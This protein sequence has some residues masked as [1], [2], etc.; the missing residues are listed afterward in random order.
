MRQNNRCSTPRP[1][2]LAK[3]ALSC[4]NVLIPIVQVENGFKLY[5]IAADFEGIHHLMCLVVQPSY[6]KQHAE[7]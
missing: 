1:H 3:D 6:S 4:Y 5:V 2:N 7:S